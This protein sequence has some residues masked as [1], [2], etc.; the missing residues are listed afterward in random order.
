M[1]KIAARYCDKI[2][3]TNE[4]PYDEDPRQILSQIKTGITESKF[5]ISNFYEILDRREAIKKALELAKEDDL[6]VITGKG[7]E[8][9]ISVAEN[10][11]IPWDDRKVV[12]E[13]LGSVKVQ[14]HNS[15][16]TRS[17]L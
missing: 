1:G 9:W 4:D 14:E 17:N 13:I 6:V 16:L 11:K 10:K 7:C 3:I 12:K 5:P 2:I 15:H 8:P